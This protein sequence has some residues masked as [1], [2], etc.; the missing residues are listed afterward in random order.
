M[1]QKIDEFNKKVEV[2]EQKGEAIAALTEKKVLEGVSKLSLGFSK[3]KQSLEESKKV[4]CDFY[5]EELNEVTQ[6]ISKK[7]EDKQITI[8][9]ISKP[10]KKKEVDLQKSMCSIAFLTSSRS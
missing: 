1:Q 4:Y 10:A 3:F 6:G 8:P 2:F 7:P 5:F 9:L